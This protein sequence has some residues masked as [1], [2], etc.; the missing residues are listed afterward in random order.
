MTIGC[1]VR[2]SALRARIAGA[3]VRLP[4]TGEGVARL[5][6]VSMVKVDI[7][8]PL[9]LPRP[10]TPAIPAACN[11]S[12]RRRMAWE[13]SEAPSAGQQYADAQT[14]AAAE[15]LFPIGALRE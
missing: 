11:P 5:V 6:E 4:G 1:S 8:E 3:V 9:A 2:P 7:G 12:W 15:A 14:L 13:L 10:L